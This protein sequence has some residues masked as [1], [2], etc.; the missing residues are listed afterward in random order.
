M[1]AFF[2]P[3][4]IP[5]VPI[6]SG[7]K[8]FFVSHNFFLFLCKVNINNNFLSDLISVT[9]GHRNLITDTFFFLVVYAYQM[10]FSRPDWVTC[11]DRKVA[12][13]DCPITGTSSCLCTYHLSLVQI[14][15]ACT[16]LSGS[17]SPF[18][19]V[20]SCLLSWLIYDFWSLFL[21]VSSLFLRR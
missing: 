12:E 9:P 13:Y 19:G 11:L 8:L 10:R 16:F 14:T 18:N 6:R 5:C 17:P 20:Y 21:I 2:F 4:I 3:G 7:T 1:P 15:I